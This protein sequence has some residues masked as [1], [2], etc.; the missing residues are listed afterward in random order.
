VNR[1]GEPGFFVSAGPAS[2]AVAAIVMTE[3]WPD[4]SERRR[5][6]MA[7]VWRP[8]EI[9]G[10]VV[11]LARHTGTRAIFDLTAGEPD[12]FAK[13]LAEARAEDI[14]LR[15]EQL[16]E[17][18]LDASLTGTGVRTLWIEFPTSLSKQE[19]RVVPVTLDKLRAHF[20][21]V[22]VTGDLQTV[23]FLMQ[24]ESPPA[25]VALKGTD[26]AGFG[27]METTGI[28][29]ATVRDR[30]LR[31]PEFARILPVVWG[32]VATAEAAA[33]F[34]CSGAGGVVF[35]SL[36]WL[37]DMVEISA[38]LRRALAN[39]RP[40]CT[41]VT[42]ERLG[43]PCR[44]FDKGNSRAVRDLAGYAS[45]LCETRITVKKRR[46]FAAR[47]LKNS[48]H[49]LQSELSADQLIP[50]G[51]E[52]SFAAGFAERFGRSTRDAVRSFIDEVA[53]LCGKAEET[54]ER[55]SDNPVTRELGTKHPIVQGGMT[56]VS[57]VPEFA[58][59][60]AEA[61]ALPTVALGVKSPAELEKDLGPL[62]EL[63]VGH[64]YAVN[65]VVLPENPF[66]DEQIAWIE[67]TRPPFAVIAGGDPSY[68][69][70]LKKRGIE[71]IYLAPDEGL[72][73][74]ALD[75]GV[76][77]L[78]LEGNEAG[79]HVG[80]HSSLILS[81][82]VL[83]AKRREPDLFKDRWIILAGGVYDRASAFRAMMMG[84]DAVQLGTAYL[85]TKEIV[86]TG[87][88][89][90]V[91]Q[92][93]ML[94]SRPGQTEVLGGSVGLNVRSL[95]T[96][97]AKAISRLEQDFAVA[98]KDEEAFR[99][100]L[101]ELSAGSL[102]IAA[103]GVRLPGGT[104]LDAK[105]C[106]R[107]G[108]FMC[109]SAAGL[110][111]TVHSIGELHDDLAH[112]AMEL[113]VPD[114]GKEPGPGILRK[115]HPESFHEPV[116]VTGMALV[117]SLGNDPRAIWEKSLKMTSGIVEVPA[118]KWDHSR[119]YDPDPRTPVKTYCK[120]GAFQDIEL[121]RKELGLPPQDFRTMS[122]STKLTLW[123]A[124]KAIA[125]SGILNSDVPS[126][127][128]AVIISQNS[129]EAS[130]TLCDLLI[131]F[132]AGELVRSLGEVV[133]LTP[134]QETAVE[135]RIR[136]NRLTVD[137]TTLL[138]R[139][140]CAAGGFI[141]NKY[142]FMGPSYSVSA[143]CA[144][145][146]VALHSAVQMIRNG[147]IDV[148]VVGGGEENLT[149]AH[150]LEFSALGALAGLSGKAFR[151][152]ES[153]R[154]F[155][156]TR[157]G[158]V[159]GEGG[160]MIVIERASVAR[161]RGAR[162]HAHITGMGA[163]NNNRGM[164]ESVSDTQE[165]ALRAA[166]EDAC[167]GADTIGLVECH[168]T[169]TMQGDLEEIKALKS[170][171][172]AGQ[173]TVLT[174][175]KSQIG[176][177]L[178]AS[179]LHSLVR[180]I[181]A[182][183][184][185]TC[186][187][188]RNYRVPDPELDVE[189]WGFRIPT[190][191]I[192]WPAQGNA[193]RR[194]LVNAF[195]FGGANYVL[196]LEECRDGEG[197][198]LV[199]PEIGQGAVD[200]AIPHGEDHGRLP[201][202]VRAFKG[203][204]GTR[205]YRIAAV[206][207]DERDAR[208]MI[209]DAASQDGDLAGETTAGL[210]RDGIFVRPEGDP[211]PRMALV[212]AGQ[213]AQYAGMG[214]ELYETVP[215]IR[216]WMDRV[217][218]S[219]NLDIL[220][221]LFHSTE[222]DLRKTRW[223]Q[224][225]LF[226]LEY[227][228]ARYLMAMGITPEVMAGHSLG[229]LTALCVAG[230]FTHE[231]G[232]SIINKRA[233]CMDKAGRNSAD[234]GAMIATDVPLDL[235]KKKITGRSNVYFTN[236]NSPRQ[237]VLG[238]R[239]TEVLK[240]R[241]ELESDGYWAAQLKVSMAFHSPIMTVIRDE[242]RE[243]IA[244]IDFHPPR[245]PVIS[246]TTRQPFPEDPEEIKR[247][248]MAHLENPVHWMQ[249]VETLWNDYGVRLFVEVGPKDTLCNLIADTFEHADCIGT[250]HPDEE[251]GTFLAAAAKLYSLGGLGRDVSA[252]PLALEHS[253]RAHRPTSSV[254][255][256]AQ[257]GEAPS[258]IVQREIGT[259]VTENFSRRLKP[260][261]LQAI[262]RETDPDFSE[263]RLDDLLRS[264]S[265]AV[266]CPAAESAARDVAEGDYLEQV[267]RIIM[268][269]TG[270]ERSEVEP[271]MDI[272]QDLAIRSTRLPVIMDAAERQFGISILVEDFIGVRTVR[273]IADR[274]AEVASR[275]G[276]AAHGPGDGE[277]SVPSPG[278][279]REPE[280][281]KASSDAEPVK[282]LVLREVL[283]D[284]PVPESLG[285]DPSGAVAVIGADSSSGLGLA[286][287]EVL[288]K[289]LDAEVVLL[290]L[291]GMDG[292]GEPASQGRSEDAAERLKSIES[293]AGVV[294]ILDGEVDVGLRSAERVPSTLTELFRCVQ[295][296][297]QSHSRRFCLLL[298]RGLADDDPAEVVFQGFL[299]I[300]LTASLEYTSVC[301]RS[302]SLDIDTKIRSALP[303]AL[304]SG[305]DELEIIYR[306]QEA[307]TTEA[308][309]ETIFS[310]GERMMA[311][312]LGSV[313]VVSGG[314]HGITSHL[315]RAL[316]PFQPK[317]VLLGRSKLDAEI[318]RVLGSLARQGVQATYH[319]CDVTDRNSVARVMAGVVEKHG[320]ID[321]I[322]HGA[323]VLRD[324]FMAF[325]SAEDF[326]E[327][328]DV[329]LMGALHLHAE[330]RKHGLRFMTGL[331][332][333]AAVFGN[334]G[335]CNYCAANRAMAS[336]IR[337][338]GMGAGKF[339]GRTFW[340]PPVEGDGMADTPETREMMALR[341]ME[342][343]YVHVDE[344]AQLFCRELLLG[345]TD[346]DWVMLAR[347]LPDVG[348]VRVSRQDGKRERGMLSVHGSAFRPDELPMIG[349]LER[350][351]FRKGEVSGHRVLSQARDVW[352]EDHVPFTFLRHP[353]VSAIMAVEMFLEAGR[354]LYPYLRPCGVREITFKDILECPRDRERSVR[355]VCRRT[356]SG[357]GQVICRAS[358]SGEPLSRT[359]KHPGD[360]SVNFQGN[361]VLRDALRPLADWP[362]FGIDKEDLDSRPM[363]H[364]E[365]LEWYEQRTNLR[366]RYRVLE[367]I[368]GS[369]QG[370]VRG[371]TVCRDINDFAGSKGVKY[372]YPVYLLEALMH[373][374]TFYTGM[375]D[376][377]EARSL[378][379]AGLKEMWF[380][381]HWN[382]G[383]RAVLE[384]RLRSKDA[385]GYVW[386]VRAVDEHAEIIMQVKGLSLIWYGE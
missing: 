64:P 10:A 185:G 313:V 11:E 123:L 289:E 210:E 29:F 293:L 278:T 54:L 148:A 191:P 130:S 223:Q 104:A 171:F 172:D 133:P 252:V 253:E 213:G 321:G 105:T 373:L 260:K 132:S 15:S 109:G 25:A 93:A 95:Q 47:V 265:Y 43:T 368:D 118:S 70:R 192:E 61:G 297:M 56:W 141:C 271:D 362:D 53:R 323:G 222:E 59:A 371:T 320:R 357:P 352:L 145:G 199:S 27:S 8:S 31:R 189:G 112:G 79:G 292:R 227:A 58:L 330:A 78:V 283:L 4:F 215:G 153:C 375:R 35:E 116:A 7:F 386:D 196:H 380:S 286:T 143:A 40:D 355:V 34:L 173:S 20:N 183:Q 73:R 233:Q 14:K 195:G 48:V 342:S 68:A 344:L 107:E 247:I 36:H 49:P 162:I 84:V 384:G 338:W 86:A 218:A 138:G 291:P 76:K 318:E 154:P 19:E 127:R 224:P 356:E 160:G 96:P 335:Q 155:D 246:N 139:L 149:Q 319:S 250:C 279:R 351:D 360:G 259:F 87:A 85:A 165:I 296:L 89:S 363:P 316:A 369:G 44:F 26:A 328:L 181:L 264:H 178:G 304:D 202:G 254:R 157:D 12:E 30:I 74:M 359:G 180:G 301:F 272:R 310:C 228:V 382:V 55:L 263:G 168:A 298:K 187:G 237:V 367:E 17:P 303:Q 5:A 65:V 300:L 176:H 331:S 152:D 175:F 108:Q 346:Q 225:A 2:C 190:E 365:V 201:D 314:G 163:S 13:L 99:H 332:S 325:M 122:N 156:A 240:L 216:H 169:S 151:P 361:V 249:N 337:G 16:V 174:S 353:V 62:R 245:T 170:F 376:E 71:T 336:M 46:S 268:N 184:D 302:V 38:D 381:R 209:R 219:A 81:Q 142:G 60:V 57:D 378:I 113:T 374:V 234:P 270:Y 193:A 242:L 200:E 182:M 348:G 287:A 262:R 37:T 45:S 276:G 147:I 179:G 322:I 52:A 114:F 150:Y 22:P 308:V 238:G 144:T 42:G 354:V 340:L 204:D 241:D 106:W 128:I 317:L 103:R 205:R 343:A 66:R 167:Y 100:R 80:R 251:A 358:V 1:R 295:T 140:N 285:L 161:R 333:L 6:V 266:T 67:E 366:G 372:Q 221:L 341:G 21:C 383:E 281:D 177:T 350:I 334:I 82:I 324:A 91:Y 385:E 294:V 126:E 370:V 261:I 72:M 39:L 277:V 63:M 269:A 282:R 226:T 164:V 137:D 50:L 217:A 288:E 77:Y 131:S 327:V 309:P 69:V 273:E 102:L 121:S 51:P 117:N 275:S 339:A 90:R 98:R 110:I 186:P 134:E 345:P 230:V 256:P 18:G 311:L 255:T 101:E 220:D 207:T 312:E 146:L 349:S 41:S 235:L 305:C 329:K 124:Q 92:R 231:A 203:D 120:V 377:D 136:S 306:G 94:D 9:D 125:E 208:K 280:D 290:D 267:I 166:F 232:F 206:A 248:V 212:F 194:V 115:S 258:D 347:K 214:K 111:G 23:S 97:K 28:L 119:I 274:I 24:Q 198:V 197:A 315:A 83:E 307:Y 244:D 364:E 284:R 326:A 3:K 75:A 239:T 211:C 88:L 229:E 236:F 299:G 158:M 243:F 129:G 135:Q 159:L 33:A 32:G 379:P 257:A 188:T